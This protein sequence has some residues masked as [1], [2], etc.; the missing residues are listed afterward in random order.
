MFLHSGSEADLSELVSG[1][2]TVRD[3]AS[4][5]SSSFV[6]KTIICSHHHHYHRHREV[7]FVTNVGT[8]I[9][10][11]LAVFFLLLTVLS[12]MKHSRQ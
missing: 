10:N 5:T 8:S 4:I 12:V 6:D 1:S 11:C 2:V 7:G 9:V 3:G